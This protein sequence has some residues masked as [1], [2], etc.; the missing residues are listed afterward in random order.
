M[1]KLRRAILA[2]AV[3]LGILLVPTAA[4]AADTIGGCN[5][6]RQYPSYINNGMSWSTSD[7]NAY[8][9]DM[10]RAGSCRHVYIRSWGVY[11]APPCQYAMVKTYNEDR[12]LRV[13]GEWKR[14]SSVGSIADLRYP[15]TN[16]RLIR[17]YAY[18]CGA[19]R[20]VVYIPGF[21][22]YTHG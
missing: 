8:H 13:K 5:F 15:V 1:A 7:E 19:Y 12:T 3:G 14:L 4:H 20:G 21:S 22:V 16:G 18:G 6:T 10:F 2:V 11:G 17:I 9:T